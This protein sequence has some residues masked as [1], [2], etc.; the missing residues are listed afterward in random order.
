M[1]IG[2]GLLF[3]DNCAIVRWL[4]EGKR[5]YVRATEIRRYIAVLHFDF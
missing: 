5:F 3:F 4:V 2:E 1:V